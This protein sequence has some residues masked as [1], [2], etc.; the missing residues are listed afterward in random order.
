[1]I[2]Y[3]H[4]LRKRSAVQCKFFHCPSAL[5]LIYVLFLLIQPT[6]ATAGQPL[7]IK[8][9]GGSYPLGKHLE[10]LEDPGGKLTL[11]QVINE[12]YA[13]SFAESHQQYPTFGF[14]SSAYWVRFSIHGHLKD[15]KH[16]LLEIGY[17][18]FDHINI[19]IP[20]TNRE[21]LEKTAG[22]LQPFNEREIKNRNF[23][24]TIPNSIPEDKPI[25]IRFKTES[26]MNLLLTLWSS[27]AFAHQDHNSQFGLGLYYGFILTMI[28]YS[29]VM[30]ITLRDR[31]YFFY[32]FFIVSFGL[33]Q[34][35]IN[36]SSY[37]YLWPTLVWW[38][39]Y[40]VPIFVSCSV[41]GV[42]ML[43]RG[44]LITARY[45]PLL[46][47]ILLFLTLGCMLPILLSIA[48]Y[49]PLAI[50]LSV[51]LA[52]ITMSVS[53]GA[54]I[55]CLIKKYR[56]A[57]YFMM[58]WTMFLVGVIV[59]ALRAFGWLPANAITLSS[60][61]YGSSLTMLLLALALADRF[62]L[63]KA[64][65]AE[66]EKKYQTIFENANEGIFRTTPQGQITMA[67]Q[68]LADIFGYA[69][70]D[71]IFTE[72]PDINHYYVD[73]D[74]RLDLLKELEAKGSIAN[75]EARMY[76]RD[77]QSVIDISINA[78]ATLN[79]KE[80]L[81]Y[82]DGMLTDITA[83]KRAEELRVARDAAES[84]NR[85]K[86]D[87]L[88][89]MSHE[90]RTPMNGIIGM[91]GLLLEAE[92]EPEQR[93]F[94]RT[95]KTSAD[96]LLAIINDILDFS[97]IEAGKLDLEN[98]KFDLN[99][100][101]EDTY[102]I[103]VLKAQQKG[104]QLI[105]KI[106]WDVPC[107]LLGDPGRL[108]QIIINLANNAI[109]FT[110]NGKI[111]ITVSVLKNLD[112]EVKLLFKVTDTGIGISPKK[113]NSLFSPFI[114]ADST[115]TRKYGGTGLGLSIARQL[116]E[117]MSGEIGV[118]SIP[119]N[120]STFWF[121]AEF[122]KQIRTDRDSTESAPYLSDRANCRILFVDDNDTSRHH[123]VQITEDWGCP[124]PVQATD[125]KSALDILG[126][127]AKEGHPFDLAVIDM[128]MPEMDG[129]SLGT[130]IKQDP[131]LSATK[132]ILITAGGTRGDAARLMEKGF[133]AYLTKPISETILKNCLD[134]ILSDRQSTEP[135]NK[136]LITR[137]SIAE[138]YKRKIIILV[139]E[140]N[141]INQKVTRI[142][143]EKLGYQTKIVANGCE[144]LEAMRNSDFDLIIMD[145]EMPEMDGYEASRQIREWKS[146][147]DESL[148]AKSSLPIIAM[149]AH[150]LKGEREKCLEAGMN[151]FLS[152]PVKPETLAEMIKKWVLRSEADN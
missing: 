12:P 52:L 116:A 3:F 10:I 54:G 30:F 95:I 150:A 126:K 134:K 152:K 147:E 24:I 51:L 76:K 105:Y 101:M 27:D 112:S 15:T 20:K 81:L 84:A 93:D 32:L 72:D 80:E 4:L 135:E 125:G 74:S 113:Q 91:T 14:T 28:L 25:L 57:R 65:T 18:L 107:F 140:D 89:N 5:I 44:F 118:N 8:D 1:M 60:P 79:N 119:D 86:S 139:A 38:N 46:D 144:A 103:L 55:L 141:V 49:Y 62:N 145:C 33:Y 82:L 128:L 106:N 53:V 56:P 23:L 133:S 41:I 11:E 102:D 111:T 35:S 48:G 47:R 39:N 37:E 130:A 45:S 94:V 148:R 115:T 29:A 70:P 6:T 50:R 137:H 66:A 61:Q 142:T 22:D 85:A 75:F 109:K 31:N 83:K 117:M 127:A 96:A 149:T 98:I 78:R 124:A 100:T 13:S 120:G 34:V 146:A 16:W 42:G 36:G 68:T 90:I 114:Q 43:T 143:L 63:M 131:R 92:L 132:L 99:H 122:L 151:D 108:R 71:E 87:F 121:T 58:G 2:N 59:S 88:A 21:Y 17:P 26:S 77:R 73:S 9:A 64:K 40:S 136:S 69:S 19:Y 129:E 7:L 104:L 67:N 97:K 110:E 123:L 138:R